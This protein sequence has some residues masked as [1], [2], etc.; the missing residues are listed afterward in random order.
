MRPKINNLKTLARPKAKKEVVVVK[1]QEEHNVTDKMPREDTLEQIPLHM[2]D[3]LE[4]TGCIDI[5]EQMQACAPSPIQP[6]S[7]PVI[8][9][10]QS[11]NA[12]LMQTQ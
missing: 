7:V 5:E 11:A 12:S 9:V 2:V 1:I 6:P 10:S 3:S 8:S 4:T